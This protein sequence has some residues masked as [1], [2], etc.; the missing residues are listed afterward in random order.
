MPNQSLEMDTL[1]NQ[2]SNLLQVIDNENT[3]IKT[4]TPDEIKERRKR[5]VRIFRPKR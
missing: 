4:S 2:N 3:D 1:L 5:V